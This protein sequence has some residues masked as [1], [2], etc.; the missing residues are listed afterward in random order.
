M[1]SWSLQHSFALLRASLSRGGKGSRTDW[2]L[3][4]KGPPAWQRQPWHLRA[5]QGRLM[6]RR[7]RPGTLAS[8]E[9]EGGGV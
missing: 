9:L 6:I 1:S 5:V 4:A 8:L 2:L 7:G 3:L